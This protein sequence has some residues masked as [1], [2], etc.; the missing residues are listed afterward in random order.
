MAASGPP[1]WRCCTLAGACRLDSAEPLHT[2]RG[3]GG[4]GGGPLSD[5]D[6]SIVSPG[7]DWLMQFSS[8]LIS[9]L[10]FYSHQVWEWILSLFS[11]PHWAGPRLSSVMGRTTFFGKWQF[12]I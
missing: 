5:L 8:N 7:A 4:G 2:C 1:D 10:Y 9:I 12:D 3:G 6:G 11:Q